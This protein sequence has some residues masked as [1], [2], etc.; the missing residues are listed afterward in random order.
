MQNPSQIQNSLHHHKKEFDAGVRITCPSSASQFSGV[1]VKS[2]PIA[3]STV[4]V[5]VHRPSVHLCGKGT[6]QQIT[7]SQRN[8]N[9]LGSVCLHYWLRD[10]SDP[11]GNPRRSTRSTESSRSG[12]YVLVVLHGDDR[13]CLELCQHAGQPIS[14]RSWRSS[15]ISGTGPSHILLDTNEGTRP[16]NRNQ[17]FRVETWRSGRTYAL[18]VC[19]KNESYGNKCRN[20]SLNPLDSSYLVTENKFFRRTISFVVSYSTVIAGCFNFKDYKESIFHYTIT[21]T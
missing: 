9:G 13:S 14:V 11:V 7:G 12:R 6:D 3:F 2:S 19:V 21:H 17:L 4:V 10:G 8:A 1:E 5:A 20:E 16:R 15:S 18:S